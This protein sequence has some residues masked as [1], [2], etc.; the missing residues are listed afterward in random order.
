MTTEVKPEMLTAIGTISVLIIGAIVT[1]IVK[2]IKALRET[3]VVIEDVKDLNATQDIKLDNITLLVDG[4]YGEVLKELA[5][6][7]DLLA[8]ETG[9]ASDRKAANVAEDK[10]QDQKFR[11]DQAADIAKTNADTEARKVT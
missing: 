10:Y 4:R 11:V 8:L 1:G 7:A 6:L 3:K 9:R 2:I 5:H